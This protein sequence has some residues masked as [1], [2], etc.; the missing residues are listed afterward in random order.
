[1]IGVT[2][3]VCNIKG[4]VA[5][6]AGK[7]PAERLRAGRMPGHWLLARLGKGV[8][9]PGGI[10][11]TREMLDGLGI[12]PADQVVGFARGLGSTARLA[13]ERGTTRI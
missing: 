5:E 6:R 10:D 2:W 11:L 7:I 1:M 4:A 13:L 3:E 8:L 12:S 9:P